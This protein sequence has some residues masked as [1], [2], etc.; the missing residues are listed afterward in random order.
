MPEVTPIP[1]EV[2]LNKPSSGIFTGTGL[3]NLLRNMEIRHLVFAG[4]SVDGAVEASV[5]SAADR[6]YEVLLVPDACIAPATVERRLRMLESGTV[7]VRPARDAVER[8]ATAAG[9]R[10]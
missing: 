6:D 4:V 5:R 2:V 9:G 7:T 8:L 1:G 3:D 10:P